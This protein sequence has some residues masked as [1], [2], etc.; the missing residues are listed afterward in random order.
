MHN[1]ATSPVP[2]ADRIA[3]DPLAVRDSIGFAAL[4]DMAAESARTV[5]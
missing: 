1:P 5:L 3:D 2:I 4:S